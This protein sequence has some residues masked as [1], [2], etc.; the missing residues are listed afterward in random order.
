MQ[1]ILG[2]DDPVFDELFIY[3][4][5]RR[6]DRALILGL[7]LAVFGLVVNRW[8]VTLSGLIVPPVWSPGV[9]GRIVVH[10]YFP[11]LMEIAVSTGIIGYGF[12]MFTLG[13][14]HLPL[15]PRAE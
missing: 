11:S 3:P 10:T 12:L 13:V 1:P 2:F 4:P 14:K 8:N 9:L 7:G 6:N 5:L 15:Y